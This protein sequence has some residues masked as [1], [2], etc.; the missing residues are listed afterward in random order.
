MEIAQCEV[1]MRIK[2]EDVKH[3]CIPA[4]I[5]GIIGF[6]GITTT[7]YI[8]RDGVFW[9]EMAQSITHPTEST[10]GSSGIS[11]QRYLF[12]GDSQRDKTVT[13]I[14]VGVNGI[15][16]YGLSHHL[17]VFAIYDGH[18]GTGW[19][20]IAVTFSEA[21]FRIY[22]NGRFV[23][24]GS[25][26]L[27]QQPVVAPTRI[28]GSVYGDFRGAVRDVRIWD[29]ALSEQEISAERN[30]DTASGGMI[31]HLCLDDEEEDTAIDSSGASNHANL[32]GARRIVDEAGPAI[33]LEQAGDRVEFR[34]PA[35]EHHFTVS[36]WVRTAEPHAIDWET[37][38][39]DAGF[40]VMLFGWHSMLSRVGL[41]AS[42]R[43]WAFAG[44]ILSVVF[45]LLS[46]I[47]FYFLGK[48]L[49]GGR[50]A[51]WAALILIVL[52]WP[53]EWGHDVLREWPNLLFLS[54][55][56]LMVLWAFSYGRP[57]FLLLAGL[58]AGTGH[59]LR[60]ECLQIVLLALAGL[61]AAYIN[62]GAF[63]PRK[64]TIAGG[65]YLLFGFG[66]VFV[67]YAAARGRYVPIRVER[68]F[69]ERPAAGAPAGQD[70]ACSSASET[71][72]AGVLSGPLEGTTVM[73]QQLNEN[74]YY[75]F[76][77]FMAI[78]LFAYFRRPKSHSFDRWFVTAVIVL[79]YAICMTLY[80]R[81]GHIGRRYVLPLTAIT[82][83]FVPLGLEMAA[84]LVARKKTDAGVIVDA[85]Q[86]RF[87]FLLLIV[88]GGLICLPKLVKPKGSNIGFSET[89]E[90]LREQTAA[91]AVIAVPD[92]RIGFY[93][94]RKRVVYDE[95]PPEE[96]WD[97][98][99]CLEQD[100][101]FRRIE[102][103]AISLTKVYSCPLRPRRS[104]GRIVT[105]RRTKELQ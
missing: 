89:A 14:S 91:D 74:L 76:F 42:G 34:Y 30:I 92:S 83:L 22:L 38:M 62:P 86:Q 105:Y 18:L 72:Y 47:P 65:L 53:A 50:H 58:L 63:M 98:L 5:V 79:N 52:P 2:P 95:Q 26:A 46:L 28:G 43:D 88:L 32:I 61:A 27:A 29:R 8:T 21:Q 24:S 23:R 20:H 3:L 87:V 15:S 35:P 6:W 90:Y 102:S 4:F 41:G 71:Q 56:L 73:I 49:V 66:I 69:A 33:Q 17:P 40:P 54:G 44:Q 48:Q 11:G 7:R 94:D 60:P 31:L 78:G 59:T 9:I 104:S 19:N 51:F 97:Y 85:K 103:P 77:P 1:V 84:S 39:R 37:A 67:P 82:V 93:A 100:R 57:R 45:R 12:S 80:L 75:F 70:P 101:E 99:V 64:K 55:G 25:T 81:W 68:L 96:G 16:V 36:A 13:H 10:S